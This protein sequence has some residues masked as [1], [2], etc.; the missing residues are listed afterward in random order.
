MYPFPDRLIE[1]DEFNMPPEA[2]ENVYELAPDAFDGEGLYAYYLH[3]PQKVMM[4]KASS[5]DGSPVSFLSVLL[6]RAFQEF[7]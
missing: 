5:S 2:P 7:H 1:T 6:Y 4:A 3:I